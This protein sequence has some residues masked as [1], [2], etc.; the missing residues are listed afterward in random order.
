MKPIKVIL[1]DDHP[2]SI[3]IIKNLISDLPDFQFIGQC[4][5]GVQLVE[6]VMVKKPDLVLTTVPFPNK[7]GMQAIKEC[8]SVFPMIKVIFI[9][10]N[11]EF[12]I[13][14]FE[15][16]AID[17][18]VKPV[19]KERLFQ[20]LMKA[21]NIISYERDKT[22]NSPQLQQ[23]T[24]TLKDQNAILFIPLVDIFFIEKVGKKCLVYTNKDIYDTFETMGRI[25][26]RLDDSFFH[27][28][29]S[30]LINLEKISQITPQKETFIVHF[31]D[32]DKLAKVSKLKINQM[33]EQISL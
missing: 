4:E 6:I 25:I 18:M 26:T 14:A 23:K 1:A 17:Y 30:Y 5:N 27:G 3:E 21:K 2:E 9:T 28:H 22:G 29:R 11:D 8:M 19:N 16:G 20:A 10:G 13:E 32:Y 15:I 12:A 33:R 31:K 24:L 7:D